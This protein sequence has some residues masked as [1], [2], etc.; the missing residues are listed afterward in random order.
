M[1]DKQPDF[2]PN[3]IFHIYNH[4]NGFENIYKTE[5]NYRF[6]LEKMSNYLPQVVDMLAYCLLPNH[7]HLLVLV[8]PVDDLTSFYQQKFDLS[9]EKLLFRTKEQPI[10]YS[11]LVR[12]QVTNFLGSYVKSFN[13]LNGRKGSL[14]RQ[15]T[16][17]KFVNNDAYFMNLIH[18]LH[19]NAVHHGFVGDFLDWPHSSYHTL[20]SQQPTKLAR[21]KILNWFGGRDAFIRFHGKKPSEEFGFEKMLECDF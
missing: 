4:A 17:R 21:T 6:F 3:G 2:I 18:Y 12:K 1:T 7:F 9:E 20:I 19:R 14:L 13:K 16:N 10:D 11:Y 5:E 8:K 15:N